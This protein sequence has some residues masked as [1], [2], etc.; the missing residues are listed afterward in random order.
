SE[1]SVQEK[2]SAAESSASS[3]AL[4]GAIELEREPVVGTAQAKKAVVGGVYIVAAL[5]LL[6]FAARKK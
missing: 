6:A 1:P 4:G 2:V 3:A 5:I